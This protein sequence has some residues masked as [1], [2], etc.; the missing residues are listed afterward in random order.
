M[1]NEKIFFLHL[2]S[3]SLLLEEKD[4]FIPFII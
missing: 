4:Y 2:R 1:N 3:Y